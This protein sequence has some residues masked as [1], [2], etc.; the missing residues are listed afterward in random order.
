LIRIRA[1]QLADTR[2]VLTQVPRA[3]QQ[4]IGDCRQDRRRIVV[5][6]DDAT[7]LEMLE[8][9]RRGERNRMAIAF[10]L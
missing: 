9:V 3:H 10:A 6:L 5:P 2:L 1:N 7:I 8:F 4:A